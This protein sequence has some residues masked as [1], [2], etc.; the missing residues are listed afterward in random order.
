MSAQALAQT[1]AGFFAE[2]GGASLKL[3]T[4]WFGR[5]YD[6]LHQLSS[7]HVVAERLIIE[8]D[9]QMML[10]L[11]HPTDAVVDGSTLRLSGFTH[12]SWDWDEYGTRVPHLETFQ[13]GIVEFVASLV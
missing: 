8:L 7:V 13:E 11:S 3:P 9:G 4:G 2:F 5:P 6:N 10:L 12:G 1:V